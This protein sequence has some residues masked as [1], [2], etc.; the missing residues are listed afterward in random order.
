MEAKHFAQSLV[1]SKWNADLTQVDFRGPKAQVFSLH[2]LLS[3]A[4]SPLGA[5]CEW[6]CRIEFSAGKGSP[7]SQLL[8]PFFFTKSRKLIFKLF[9]ELFS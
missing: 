7:L 9:S 2:I 1:F 8:E 3:A 4:S 6:S 5:S